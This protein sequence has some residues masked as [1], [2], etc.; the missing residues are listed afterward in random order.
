MLKVCVIKFASQGKL[1]S[2]DAFHS[3]LDSLFKSNRWVQ[4]GGTLPWVDIERLYND[5]LN[6]GKRSAGNK[7]AHMI[8]GTLLIEHKLNLSDEETILAIH[9][10][11]NLQYFVGHSEFTDKPVLTRVC[12]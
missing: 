11:I 2:I 1:F 10:N 6:N 3:S 9:E 5:H 7:P 8:I 4:L 12:S